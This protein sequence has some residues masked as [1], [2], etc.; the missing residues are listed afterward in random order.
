MEI[1]FP[2]EQLAELQFDLG[3]A[4][5]PGDLVRVEL[6]EKVDVT[7]GPELAPRGGSEQV[8]TPDAMSAAERAQLVVID[9]DSRGEIHH[10][11]CRICLDVLHACR[12]QAR[13]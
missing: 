10:V 6:D 12:A 2:A 4:Q 13:A 8:E 7:V 5:E 1:D 9:S 3:D 11:E